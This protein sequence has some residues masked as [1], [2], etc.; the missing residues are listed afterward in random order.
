MAIINIL[1]PI[2]HPSIRVIWDVIA[3]KKNLAILMAIIPT[4]MPMKYDVMAIEKIN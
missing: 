2:N 3:I 4:F 1:M